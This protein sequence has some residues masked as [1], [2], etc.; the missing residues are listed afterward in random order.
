M[1]EYSPWFTAHII[2][3]SDM[4]EVRRGGF[5]WGLFEGEAYAMITADA[6]NKGEIAEEGH[7]PDT[8]QEQAEKDMEADV[9]AAN[10]KWEAWRNKCG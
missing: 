1:T 10:K 6:L 5:L 8:D 3:G 4:W 7:N 9:Q 2:K